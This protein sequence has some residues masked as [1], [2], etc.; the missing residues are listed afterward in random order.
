MLHDVD[1]VVVS[2][3]ITVLEEMHLD[4]GGIPVTQE[5]VLGLLNRIGEFNEWGLN[6]ILDTVVARYVPVSEDETYAIMNVLDPLLRTSNSG[7]VLAVLKCFIN[8]TRP[9]PDIQNAIYT[10]AKTPLLTLITGGTPEIQYCI[11]KHIDIMFGLDAVRGVF[12]EDFRLFFVRYNEPPHLK[13]LKVDLLPNVVNMS[14]AV[15]ISA[16]L[17]EYVTDVDAELSKRAIR[18]IGKIAVT[19]PSV[20]SDMMQRLTEIVDLD[21]PYVREESIKTLVVVLRTFPALRL[22]VIPSLSRYLRRIEN[23]EAKAGLVWMLGE[24]ATEVV[25]APYMLERIIDAYEEEVSVDIKLQ[26][27]V[28]TM[29]MF[30][31]RPPEVHMMLGRLLQAAVN[32]TSNQDLHDRALLYYRLLSGGN[33]EVAKT[34]FS[35]SRDAPRVMSAEEDEA[36]RLAVVKAF[37]EDVG[38]ELL[39]KI[40]SEFNSL[41]ILY[42]KPS[43]HF[44]MDKYL[45]N[46]RTANISHLTHPEEHGVVPDGA[47]AGDYHSPAAGA[48]PR[49]ISIDFLDMGGESLLMGTGAGAGSS[50]A[51]AAPLRPGLYLKPCG[52]SAGPAEFNLTPQSFQQMWGSLPDAFNGKLCTLGAFPATSAEVAAMVGNVEV[53]LLILNIF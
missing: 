39:D 29:K 34:M 17:S 14:N 12:D 47:G 6:L 3:V 33:I 36:G 1:A 28:A 51:P 9:F 53:N 21:V 43:S 45:L 15:D 11:F 26:T 19:I 37:A 16:E 40:Y 20:S 30:F 24:Y 13:H 2:N 4:Q 18:A 49:K 5:L 48:T 7:T 50:A 35:S 44:I 27:L 8:L 25:E 10:R 42:D 31:Q 52:P 22:H 23:P 46:V 41:A 32:D 38:G